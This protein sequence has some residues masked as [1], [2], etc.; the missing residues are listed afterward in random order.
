MPL[1]L[2]VYLTAPMT[3]QFQKLQKK[4]VSIFDNFSRKN[5]ECSP[6]LQQEKPFYCIAV[7]CHLFTIFYLFI[8]TMQINLQ[9]QLHRVFGILSLE[10]AFISKYSMQVLLFE[11]NSNLNI[12]FHF[13]LFAQ[14]QIFHFSYIIM[15]FIL[16]FC[17]NHM[18]FEIRYAS[19]QQAHIIT[20]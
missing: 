19:D 8:L 16:I 11:F 6:N 17:N 4:L 2:L 5:L 1:I 15:L 18:T 3:Y 20:R 7:L 10:I 13:C 12:S 14:Y 9:S